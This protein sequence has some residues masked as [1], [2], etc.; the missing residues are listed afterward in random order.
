ML[1]AIGHDYRHLI[2]S[3]PMQL[4]DGFA[5][6]NPAPLLEKE[7]NFGLIALLVNVFH[8]L[9]LHRAGARA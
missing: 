8:P 6:T 2:V 9:G 7:G 5:F 4:T 1:S 3:T